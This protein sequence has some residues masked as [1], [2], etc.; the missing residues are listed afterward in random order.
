MTT[1]DEGRP[2]RAAA[3]RELAA[4]STSTPP[5]R[6]GQNFVVDANTV[7][8]IVRIAPRS[9]GRRSSSRSAPASVRSR[10]ACCPGAGRCSRSRSTRSWRVRCPRPSPPVPPRRGSA[11]RRAP[12]MP[13]WSTSSRR[14]PRRWSPTCP[15]NVAVPVLLHLLER[16]PSL[17][18]GLVM[19][20][21]EV[22]ERLAASPGSKVYGVPSAKAAWYAEVTRAGR[23]P[24][25]VFWPV[26]NV[27]SGL[28]AFGRRPP[29][30]T[31]ASREQVFACIDAAFAQRRK[32]LR[33]A[34]AGWAG[35]V[36]RRGVRAAGG[37]RRPVAAGRGDHG[38]GLRSAGGAPAAACRLGLRT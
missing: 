15:Y 26:P 8:R 37:R 33:S 2:A 27:D 6:W 11:D 13:C 28:V 23:V 17:A 16:F 31:T 29:P 25:S 4:G 24:R 35:G 5:R 32:S 1:S 10:S 14:L 19:V 36:Q 7:R 30:D 20:Q 3:V 18:H 9:A 22:A 12:A 21:L 34:L 38:R